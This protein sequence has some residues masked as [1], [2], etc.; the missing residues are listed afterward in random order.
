MKVLIADSMSSKAVE[1]LKETPG[2]DVDVI[3]GLKPDE[4][5]ARIKD[6]H[7]LVV[8]SATKATA[9]IIEAAE[10]LKVIGRAGTGVD[11]VDTV[12]AT[13]KGIV[14]MNTPGGNTI[15][16]AEHAVSMMMA[17]ARKIPRP[18]PPRRR[19]EWEKKRHEGTEITGKTLMRASQHRRGR[20]EPGSRP[21]HERHSLRPLH[22]RRGRR[23]DRHSPG[24]H[25]R[26][27]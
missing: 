5:K 4:L 7:G 14:V 27:L 6:Y 9:E 8:R 12:A 22:I 16:T 20:R 25:G 23:Q 10:N 19:G 11:N 18:R 17:L 13:K 15:T 26:P 2:I 3:T 24:F 21:S 1:I